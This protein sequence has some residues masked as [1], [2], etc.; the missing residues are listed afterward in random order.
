MAPSC[1]LQVNL[2]HS[3]AA[4]DLLC[5]HAAEWSIDLIIVTEPYFVPDRNDWKGD[6]E[7]SVAIV[8]RR[9]PGAPPS[10]LKEKGEGYVA[11]EWG[12]VLVIGVYA[13][14]G[15]RSYGLRNC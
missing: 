15:G 9:G 1:V 13:P 3:A 11:V 8:N 6:E 5:Q 12:K 10:L 4:Q 2:N 7:G 14:P